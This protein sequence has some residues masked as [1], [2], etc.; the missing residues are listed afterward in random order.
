[1]TSA[2]PPSHSPVARP[3]AL[4]VVPARLGSTRLERKMLLHESGA[5]L[6][7]HTVR[8]A[9]S[10]PALDRVVLA[11]DSEEILQAARSVGIE[12]LLTSTALPSGTDRVHAAFAE[13]ARAGGPPWDVV[14]NIQGDEPELD[15]SALETLVDAFR[16]PR[17]ELASLWA[18]LDLPATFA[19]PA[20]VKVVTDAAGDA[21]YFSRAPIPSRAHPGSVEAGA[22]GAKLHLGVYAFRP[23]ALARFVALPPSALAAAEN[24]EQLRWL[25]AGGKIRML[26]A[27]RASRGID[28]LEDYRAF[29]ARALGAARARAAAPPGRAPA[30]T[31]GQPAATSGAPAA[32]KSPRT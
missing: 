15:V 12:A 1:M 32:G 2:A 11:T 10:S 6:F 23:P 27:A 13:L 20:A 26:R 22:A 4:A 28:T 18:E 31:A 17:V 25:E 9:Q 14:L 19:D 16:D 21:L 7:E 8:N 3:R 29:V 5:Y 24:L 30:P